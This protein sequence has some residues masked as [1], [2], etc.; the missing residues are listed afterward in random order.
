MKNIKKID[1]S[2]QL[3]HIETEASDIKNVD[4]ESEADETLL[5]SGDESTQMPESTLDEFI[6][7][8]ILPPDATEKRAL[9]EAEDK[10]S[11]DS[12]GELVVL[13]NIGQVLRNA[14][15]ERS[16]SIDDISR[17][18]R[19][20]VQQVEAIER[21][22]F[23]RLPPGRTFLR[24]FI[25][26][27][28]NL[29]KLDPDPILQRLPDQSP[30]VS[31]VVRTP[32]Q[33]EEMS[34]SSD[35]DRSRN[36]LIFIIMGL[37]VLAFIVYFVYPSN[38]WGMKAGRNSAA[39][40]DSTGQ[41]LIQLDLPLSSSSAPTGQYAGVTPFGHNQ[42]KPPNTIS[43]LNAFGSLHFRFTTEARV[44]VTDG[45][46]KTIFEQLKVAGSEQTISGKR[47]LFVVV[48]NAS[49]VALTY[50]E[51]P[52]EI[53]PYMNKEDGVARFTLE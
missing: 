29:V 22:A 9:A 44:I 17:Q 38:D 42:L 48:H 12:G 26:N 32:F 27:Y 6:A 30:A 53:K 5:I 14:R 33:I 40:L 52:I 50:N 20:S 39:E 18:L 43:T 2:D 41:E 46:G 19:L 10:L 4:V 35:Q 28:A 8:Y 34:Y 7:D 3:I 36:K 49:G 24:G 16:M 47:P 31:P 11:K 51:R 45:D 13:P 25:R 1:K 23:D 15:E 21:D 37:I